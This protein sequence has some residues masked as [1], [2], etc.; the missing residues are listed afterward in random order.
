[1][2]T[3]RNML[4]PASLER[5]WNKFILTCA[6]SCRLVF[7]EKQ[8]SSL[9]LFWKSTKYTSVLFLVNSGWLYAADSRSCGARGRWKGSG[10]RESGKQ[11][12]LLRCPYRAVSKLEGEF[13]DYKTNWYLHFFSPN[14]FSQNRFPSLSRGHQFRGKPVYA[15]FVFLF[16]CGVMLHMAF[17]V[18]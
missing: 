10:S 4:V 14:F 2:A 16:K 1:M 12:L 7:R 6:Y 13:C 15:L 18:F 5:S 3:W 17:A 8:R 11:E 9:P